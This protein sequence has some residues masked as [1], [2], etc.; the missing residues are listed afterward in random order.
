MD[1]ILEMLLGL[2]FLVETPNL[3]SCLARDYDA[4]ILTDADTL[5]ACPH[6]YLTRESEP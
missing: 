1:S 4:L 2:G 5:L 3:T 6:H